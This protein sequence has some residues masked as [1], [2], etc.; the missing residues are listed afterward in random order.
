[1]LA[2]AKKAAADLG[3]T[4][5]LVAV[6]LVNAVVK[7]GPDNKVTA[8]TS[9]NPDPDP[10]LGYRLSIPTKLRHLF[11]A[12]NAHGTRTV[13]FSDAALQAQTHGASTVG[14]P[15]L[16]QRALQ[17]VRVMTAEYRPGNEEPHPALH[18]IIAAGISSLEDGPLTDDEIAFNQPTAEQLGVKVGDTVRLDYFKRQDN[19]ELVEVKSSDAGLT[20]HV[21]RIL[22]MTG[23]AAD[24]TLTPT[25]KGMT[26]APSVSDWRPPR[27]LHIDEKLAEKDNDAYWRKYKAAPRVFVSLAAAEK[28][29]G[30]VY[31][32]VTSV[33]VPAEK[34][35]AF[36]AKLRDAL[37][38]AALGLAF[39]PVKAQQIAAATSGGAEEFGMIFIGLSFFLIAAAALLVAMLFRLN[40]EQ[41]ARQIGLMAAIGFTPKKLRGIALLEGVVLAVIGGVVGLAGAVG[42]TALMI[43][44]LNTRWNGASAPIRCAS[45]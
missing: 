5:R 37:D 2:A 11:E 18:Y 27:E 12:V 44:G 4:P 33:R 41:R 8:S 31:G 38:P 10:P 24:R 36:A 9:K 19:G 6:N 35:D 23:L 30:G 42:Y 15:A 25:Y 45:M 28:M 43:Y 20:F 21:A 13:G 34:A 40:I 16:S 14:V 1:M 32:D 39:R 3:V 26:D 29:W 22:P 17:H 7:V